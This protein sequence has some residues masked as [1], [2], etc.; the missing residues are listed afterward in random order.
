MDIGMLWFDWQ[1]RPHHLTV[2]MVG[3]LNVRTNNRSR[4]NVRTN[5]NSIWLHYDARIRCSVAA[6]AVAFRDPCHF[7]KRA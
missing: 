7:A 6:N 1:I 2:R 5:S 3:A 4:G